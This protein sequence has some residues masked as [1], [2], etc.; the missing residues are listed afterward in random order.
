MKDGL[1]WCMSPPAAPFGPH[2][3]SDLSPGYAKKRTLL[4]RGSANRSASMA[5]MSEAMSGV[6]LRV[7][8]VAEFIIGRAFARP[9]GSCG[10]PRFCRSDIGRQ[11][12]ERERQ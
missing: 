8:H 10:L 1:L 12:V 11:A 5:R 7:P 2:A 4:V 3:I 6:W 9:G